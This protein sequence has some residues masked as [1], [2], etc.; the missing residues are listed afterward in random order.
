MADNN[1]ERKPSGQKLEAHH[2]DADDT[3]PL[4]RKQKVNE[5]LSAELAKALRLDADGADKETRVFSVERREIPSEGL[6]KRL[7]LEEEKA[8]ESGDVVY[9]GQRKKEGK[10]L[11]LRLKESVSDGE[12]TPRK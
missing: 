9:V 4:S 7:R 12:D 6:A 8:Q 5:L 2:R 10:K 1:V 11:P 3:R